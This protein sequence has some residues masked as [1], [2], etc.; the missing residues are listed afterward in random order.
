VTTFLLV[1]HATCD[2]VGRSIAGRLPGIPLNAEGR[3]QAA[4]L[5]LRLRD[6]ALDAIYSSP[7]QRARETAD[8]IA[9]GRDVEVRLA[10]ELV[11]LD[12]AEWSGRT[13][14]ELDDDPQWRRF[15][16]LRSITRASSGESMLSVQSRA[17]ALLERLRVEHPRGRVALVSHG[18][19]IRGL[20]AH[21]AGIPLDLFQRLEIDPASVSVIDVGDQHVA[22]RCINHTGDI[23]A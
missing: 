8:A 11:E 17:V 13:L 5:A 19:V 16:Q 10:D 18:D 9:E 15:N 22:L 14:A 20:V 3:E 7:I 21:L 23:P 6:L 2:P 12:F 4:R 1:R